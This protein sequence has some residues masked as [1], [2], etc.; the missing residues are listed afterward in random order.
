MSAKISL[1]GQEFGSWKVLED[2]PPKQFACGSIHYRSLCQCKCGTQ[3]FVFN[4]DLVR[5]KSLRCLNCAAVIVGDTH[6]IHGMRQTRT[7]DQWRSM[8]QRCTNPKTEFWEDY[9][10][11]GITVCERWRD[12]RNFLADMGVCPDGLEIDRWPDTNGNYEKNNCRWATEKEQARNKRNNRV[13][14]ALGVTACFSELC[15]RFQISY[16]VA[17]ARLKR[18]WL[19]DDIFSKSVRP[20]QQHDQ[21][22]T[23]QGV[24]GSIAQLCKHF[25]MS[26]FVV[27]M[28]LKRGWHPDRIFSQPVRRVKERKESLRHIA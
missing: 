2:A 23:I 13:M 7:Y 3:K 17:F 25:R 1:V 16:S 11:R 24:T 22:M 19:P 14:T 20:L 26:Y 12:F 6:R 28:R 18:G 4:N 10:G 21:I 15:E 9:G 27:L 8:I 5:G